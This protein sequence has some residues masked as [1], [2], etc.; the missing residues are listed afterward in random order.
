MFSKLCVG[1]KVVIEWKEAGC[2]L[3]VYIKVLSNIISL[4]T[5]QGHFIGRTIVHILLQRTAYLPTDNKK[6]LGCWFK[7]HKPL[8]FPLKVE[9]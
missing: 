2:S 5:G 7:P 4:Q 1:D 9:G 6:D 8:I 3:T